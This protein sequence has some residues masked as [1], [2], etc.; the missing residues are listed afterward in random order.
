MG[1]TSGFLKA[2]VSINYTILV[3]SVVVAAF[4]GCLFYLIEREQKK[5]HQKK[6]R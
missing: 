2:M 5:K 6:Q 3:I 4:V 1:T